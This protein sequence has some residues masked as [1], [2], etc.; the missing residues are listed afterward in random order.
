MI[1][2]GS[3]ITSRRAGRSQP[4]QLRRRSSMVSALLKCFRTAAAC[5]HTRDQPVRGF[6]RQRY[7]DRALAAAAGCRIPAPPA[8]AIVQ[9]SVIGDRFLLTPRP[10][11]QMIA[12]ISLSTVARACRN[13]SA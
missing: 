11:T 3:A 5:R 2:S 8:S 6:V 12:R 10:A 1:S 9:I 7:A 4:E 13:C